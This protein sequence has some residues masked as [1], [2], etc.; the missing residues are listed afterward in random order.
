M[1]NT[2][3]SLAAPSHMSS[4]DSS[5]TL[6]E[7]P[8]LFAEEEKNQRSVRELL[9]CEYQMWD[10]FVADSPQSSVFCRTWWLKS[11]CSRVRILGC[12]KNGHLEAGIPLHFE[13][14]YGLSFCCMPRLT[15]T[16]GLVMEPMSGKHSSIATRETELLKT[17]ATEL[18]RQHTFFQAFHPSLQNWLPFYWKGF[19]QTTRT[20]Y[21]LTGLKEPRKLWTEIAHSARTEILKAQ[22]RGLLV[23]ACDIDILLQ[24]EAKTFNR[25]KKPLPHSPDLL[26][27]LYRAAKSRGAG[28]CFAAIDELDRPHAAGFIVWDQKRTYYLVSGGDGFLRRSGATSL[29]TWHLIQFAAG[30]S[31]TFDFEGSMLQGVERFFRSFGGHQVNYNCIMKLPLWLH[32][33]LLAAHK[34]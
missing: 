11:V 9:P 2:G 8:P 1:V 15:Q 19:T 26:R 31:E 13:K 6:L 28:E 21:T 29:L 16:L 33:F 32:T 5:P 34:L 20:T 27:S 14:R 3:S 17:I 18:S 7:E 25:Q 4:L 12:F 24:L 30:R 23:T 10:D 22:R